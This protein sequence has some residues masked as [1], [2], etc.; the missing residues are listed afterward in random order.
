MTKYYKFPTTQE[1]RDDIPKESGHFSTSNT[2]TRD[3]TDDYAT[4]WVQ[5]E[6][7][8]LNLDNQDRELF[9]RLEKEY[10]EYLKCQNAQTNASQV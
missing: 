1:E 6:R 10:Q 3:Y 2:R 5:N 7:K 4:K 8:K 9:E